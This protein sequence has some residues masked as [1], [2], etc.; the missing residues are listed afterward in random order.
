LRIE[1]DDHVGAFVGDPDVVFFIDANGMGE[2]PSVETVTDFAEEFSFGRE[3]EEVGGGGS[4]GWAGGVAAGEY[5]DVT[6]GVDGDADGFAEVKVGGQ[7]EE[8]GDG[9]VADFGD[10]RLLRGKRVGDEE[11]NREQRESHW[12][13]SES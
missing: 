6:F 9:A 1:L 13:A 5:E 3:F 2:G 8:V 10:L 4:V 7:L 11:K 12:F